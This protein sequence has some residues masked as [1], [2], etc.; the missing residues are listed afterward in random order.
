MT[1]KR[2]LVWLNINTGEFSK[3]WNELDYPHVDTNLLLERY[4]PVDGWK[5]IEYKCLNDE[6]FQFNDLMVIK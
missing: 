2:T 6:E 3:S 4:N 1:K 5:L